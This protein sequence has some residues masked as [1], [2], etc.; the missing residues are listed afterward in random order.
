MN[1]QRET[2][3]RKRREILESKDLKEKTLESI[4]GEV[5]KIVQFHASGYKEEWNSKEIRESLGAIMPLP[6]DFDEAVGKIET[7]ENLA[8][9]LDKLA[10]DIYEMKEKQ[11]GFEQMREIE[12]V[13]FLR[14]TDMMW[15]DHLDEMEHLRDSVRLRAYGQKD[16]LVEYKNEGHKLFQDLLAAIQSQFVSMVYKVTLTPPAPRQSHI[17]NRPSTNSGQAPSASSAKKEV[18][19]NDPC[20][21]GSGKKYKK[22]CG[23]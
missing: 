9:F 5:A 21:C 15:M 4:S 19:R 2:I 20:P 3:Y 11:I 22:C 8:G 7:S 16:P 23:K 12:K 13:L 6:A 14:T 18:G 17:A 1:K 10:K